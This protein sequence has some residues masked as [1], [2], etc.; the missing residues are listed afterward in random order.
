VASAAAHRSAL[1]LYED[2]PAPYGL[3]KQAWQNYNSVISNRDHDS[4]LGGSIK[5]S[6]R[7]AVASPN[8]PRKNQTDVLKNLVIDLPQQVHVNSVNLASSHFRISLMS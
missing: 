4:G 5:L 3:D 1:R 7:T 6:F 8:M 2:V